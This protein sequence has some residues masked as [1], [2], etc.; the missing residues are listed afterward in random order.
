M[1]IQPTFKNI[2]CL[3]YSLNNTLTCVTELATVRVLRKYSVVEYAGGG[4]VV[5]SWRVCSSMIMWI[6]PNIS[7]PWRMAHVFVSRRSVQRGALRNIRFCS[8]LS[9][10]AAQMSPLRGK[11]IVFVN[12]LVRGY[13]LILLLF[14]KY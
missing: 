1:Q 8:K 3:Q 5:T 13:F 10:A 9:R 2:K 12:L 6:Y 14:Q 11:L 7:M 4:Y